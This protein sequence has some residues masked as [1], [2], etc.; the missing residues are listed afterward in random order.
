MLYTFKSK[1]GADIIMLGHHARQLL[2]IIAKHPDAAEASAGIVLPEDMAAALH[3]LTTAIAQEERAAQ[4][5]TDCDDLQAK[6]QGAAPERPVS[7]RQRSQP[8]MQLLQR[9]ARA[10]VP[11]VWEN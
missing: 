1:A 5:G 8:L 3:A 2:A 11:I 10:G 9:S 7:L 6:V 4:A